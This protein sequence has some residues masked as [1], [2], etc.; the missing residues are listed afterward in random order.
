MSLSINTNIMANNTARNLSGHYGDL[1]KSVERLSSGL[2]VNSSSDDA[3][4]LAI[5]EMMRADIAALNQGVR[6]VNDAISMIQTA[7]GALGIID[8]KLIRMKELAE[9]AATGTYSSDQRLMI[10]SEFQAMASE[11]D[12]IAAATQFNGTHLLDGSLQGIHNGNGLLST[13]AMKIHFG[14]TNNAAEDYYYVDIP[15]ISTRNLLYPDLATQW[16]GA[17]Q[18]GNKLV[19]SLSHIIA[20]ATNNPY[21]VDGMTAIDSYTLPVGLENI[22]VR[23]RNSQTLEYH[24]PHVS[25]FTKDGEQLTGVNPNIDFIDKDGK[26]QP[27]KSWWNEPDGNSVIQK[28]K[29]AGLFNDSASYDGTN[30]INTA[31]QSVNAGDMK[32]TLRSDQAE[33]DGIWEEIHISEISSDLVFFIGGHNNPDGGC[34]VYDME[35]SADISISIDTQAKAQ[36]MLERLTTAVTTKDSI[37]AHLGAVQNRLENTA[38]NLMIQAENLQASE[39][40]ITDVDVA[41]EMTSF[42]RSQILTQS[43]TAMLSQANSLPQM[44]LQV[45]QA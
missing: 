5:R 26:P 30:I 20:G 35:I 11:I 10:D 6:N 16:P 25:L 3:A 40:R 32:V 21:R 36:K 41:T 7:D 8:E 28:G 17:K 12:R 33:T 19:L 15:L 9:Q 14:P 4:G 39:S 13:G 37:R 2:R 27:G 22:V 1:A 31:G 43:A 24:K 45:I 34:N 29:N 23:S 38:S 42:V 18:E 44:A